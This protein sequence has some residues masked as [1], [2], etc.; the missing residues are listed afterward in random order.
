MLVRDV[1]RKSV[2]TTDP[3]TSIKEAAKVMADNNIGCL[4]VTKNDNA[5][6]VLT[7]RDIIC[8][9]AASQ[10]NEMVSKTV[11]D[12]MTKFIISITSTSTIESAVKLLTENKIKKLPVID[13]KLVG[14][15]TSSDIIAAQPE[16]IK[17]VK[18]LVSRKMLDI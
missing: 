12:A 7:E 8:C 6:G 13:E 18:R 16:M 1:M 15:L 17:N 10:D 11:N 3:E 2:I 9:L 14:I 4:V 5:I